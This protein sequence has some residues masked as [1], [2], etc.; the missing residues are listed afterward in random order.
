M[1]ERNAFTN[2]IN[3]FIYINS[4]TIIME[5]L[6]ISNHNVLTEKLWERFYGVKLD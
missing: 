6:Q 2:S 3:S 4:E 1:S 5:N